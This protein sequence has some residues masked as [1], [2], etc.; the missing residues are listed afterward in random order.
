[1]KTIAPILE[2][3]EKNWKRVIEKK[4]FQDGLVLDK[5]FYGA[6]IGGVFLNVT[7][8][9]IDYTREFEEIISSLSISKNGEAYLIFCSEGSWDKWDLED[10]SV[11]YHSGKFNIDDPRKKIISIRMQDKGV[12]FKNNITGFGFLKRRNDDANLNNDKFCLPM[13]CPVTTII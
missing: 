6:L 5:E 12:V 11:F 1:M 10:F 4:L 9:F 13:I 8:A 3:S 2:N 7:W